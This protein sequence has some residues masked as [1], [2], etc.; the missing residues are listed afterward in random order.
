VLAKF[1]GLKNLIFFFA[2]PLISFLFLFSIYGYL[3]A[4]LFF[5][6]DA[7][8]Y[9]GYLGDFLS[10]IALPIGLIALIFLAELLSGE[11]P[12]LKEF[13]DAEMSKMA[14]SFYSEVKRVSSKRRK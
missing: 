7:Y 14:Q 11:I 2:F 4:I 1:F 5:F 13:K 6:K 3:F 9:S 10:R 12:P 8:C